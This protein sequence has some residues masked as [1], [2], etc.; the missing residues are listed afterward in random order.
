MRH[1]TRVAVALI[2]GLAG[3]GGAA[4]AQ[5]DPP[6]QAGRL[7]FVEGVVSFHDDEQSGWSPAT[8][9]TP[10]TSGDAIWTEPNARSEISVAGTRVRLDGGTQLDMLD[11]DDAQTR[12]QIDR[13]KIDI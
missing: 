6:G 8:V 4:R 12:L 13:G 2:V 11:V 1:S 3:F 7:A 10:L 9:N 5:G